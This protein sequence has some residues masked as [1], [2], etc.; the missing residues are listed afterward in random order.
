MSSKKL[1]TMDTK[2]DWKDEKI[3]GWGG[4]YTATYNEMA[5]TIDKLS[6]LKRDLKK[7]GSVDQAK[8]RQKLRRKK[9][10]KYVLERTDG[11]LSVMKSHLKRMK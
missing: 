11:A 8:R 6:S 5:N 3:K 4:R 10:G 1:K 2:K 9:K 7:G